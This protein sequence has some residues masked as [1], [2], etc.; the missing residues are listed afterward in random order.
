MTSP[1]RAVSMPRGGGCAIC[2]W[3]LLALIDLA[4][5]F[6]GFRRFYRMIRSW[7]IVGAVPAD[8]RP[9][10]IR[11]T[12]A[13]MRSARPYYFRRARCLQSAAATVC[14]LRLR[15]IHAELVIGVR[16]I[17][18]YAHAWVEVAGRVVINVRPALAS[19][20]TVIARC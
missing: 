12:C 15:G 11:Q 18:F 9:E 10:L 13:A 5:K 17:P 4:L 16:K 1:R 3:C 6:A 2:A 19:H 14:F 8:A 20:Y 7:P